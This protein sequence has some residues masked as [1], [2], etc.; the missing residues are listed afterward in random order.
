MS[1]FN[2]YMNRLIQ[3]V[4]TIFFLFSMYFVLQNLSDNSELI[5]I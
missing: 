3:I 2:D 4:S 1:L 5:N